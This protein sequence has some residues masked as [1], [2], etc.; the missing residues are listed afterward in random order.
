[1]PHSY[2]VYVRNHGLCSPRIVPAPKVMRT[3]KRPL[4]IEQSLF[5]GCDDDTNLR[6]KDS[7]VGEKDKVLQAELASLGRDARAQ[8]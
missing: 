4:K 6:V 8:I 2:V 1:M 3:R 5:G 7:S